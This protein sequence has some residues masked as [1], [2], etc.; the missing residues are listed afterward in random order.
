ML[1]QQ[2]GDVGIVA[3]LLDQPTELAD[4]LETFIDEGSNAVRLVGADEERTNM[5]S[6]LELL[7]RQTERDQ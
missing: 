7:R 6:V 4:A 1:D 3:N 2:H 5:S